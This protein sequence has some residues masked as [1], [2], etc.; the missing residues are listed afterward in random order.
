MG[1][2][3]T[4]YSAGGP[5]TTSYAAAF[6]SN[7]QGILGQVSWTVPDDMSLKQI[8]LTPKPL[9][10]G[11]DRGVIV[12]WRLLIEDEF[13]V[14]KTRA[15]LTYDTI[16]AGSPGPPPPNPADPQIS[17][18]EVW[19]LGLVINANRRIQ[20]KM[21]TTSAVQDSGGDL[22]HCGLVGTWLR[23]IPA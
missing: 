12:T 1:E 23:D 2:L 10:S 11:N 15:S 3:G 13:G 6:Q 14:L 16:G 19:D 7:I 20:I 9:Q 8:I 17:L 21:T 18:G 22:F 4:E 5:T